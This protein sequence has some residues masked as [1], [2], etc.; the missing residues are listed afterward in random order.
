M[1]QCLGCGGLVPTEATDCPNCVVSAKASGV[2]RKVVLAAGTVALM[3]SCFVAQ[4]VYGIPCTSKQVDG[5]TTGCPGECTT[6]IPD[7]GDPRKDP[8]NTACYVDGGVP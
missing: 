6:L 3:S 7:G 1:R 2:V 5:G 8:G 4:P